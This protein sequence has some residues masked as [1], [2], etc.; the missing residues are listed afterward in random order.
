MRIVGAEQG[1]RA[2]FSQRCREQPPTAQPRENFVAFIGLPLGQA[3]ASE[4]VL[5][6]P[7]GILG[8]QPARQAIANQR[9]FCR[10]GGPR[11]EPI[12][13]FASGEIGQPFMPQGMA[14][15]LAGMYPQKCVDGGIKIWVGVDRQIASQSRGHQVIMEKEGFE[16][17]GI[18]RL[19]NVLVDAMHRC[20]ELLTNRI[21]ARHRKRRGP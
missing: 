3:P 1:A 11:Q 16:T 8:G 4:R 18:W 12:P 14:D 9:R 5:G 6:K 15:G 2:T 17:R 20:H 21:L 19:R 13:A 7:R 10:I